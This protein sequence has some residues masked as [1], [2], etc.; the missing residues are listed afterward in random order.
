[1]AVGLERKRRIRLEDDV[2]CGRSDVKFDWINDVK[3]GGADGR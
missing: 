3:Y 1:M 2:K